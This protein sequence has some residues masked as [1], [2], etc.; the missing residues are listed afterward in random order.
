MR[1]FGA[2]LRT[3]RGAPDLGGHRVGTSEQLVIDDPE[4]ESVAVGIAVTPVSDGNEAA[5]RFEAGELILLIGD[6][7]APPVD[8]L[9]H[10]AEEQEPAIVTVPDDEDHRAFERIDAASR[11]GG[12]ALVEGRTLGATAAMLGDWDLQST[13]LRRSLQDGAVQ[14]PLAP[15][16]PEPLLVE[17]AEQIAGFERGLIAASRHAR[18]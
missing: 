12:I 8:L 3:E 4:A 10:V 17:N 6:G 5:A 1:G 13:L 15:D 2:P 14:L 9:V 18:S 7:I 16:T 11:W